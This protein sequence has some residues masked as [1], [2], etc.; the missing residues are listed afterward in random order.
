MRNIDEENGNFVHHRIGF[1]GCAY[2]KTN[3]M[4]KGTRLLMESN[5]F[6]DKA[7]ASLINMTSIKF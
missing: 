6:I 3:N 2:N 1:C 5:S 7:D 4:S